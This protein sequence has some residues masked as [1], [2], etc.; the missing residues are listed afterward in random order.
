MGNLCG[1]KQVVQSALKAEQ[2]G[3]SSILRVKVR[4]R[5]NELQEL[6]E[7]AEKTENGDD[8]DNKL[9]R[10]ILRECLDGRLQTRVT[11]A[12]EVKYINHTSLPTIKEY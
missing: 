9:G 8:A 11:P 4:M 5:V 6:M 1:K 10:L 3:R 2:S 12:L 7:K